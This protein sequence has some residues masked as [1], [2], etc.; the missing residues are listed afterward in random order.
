MEL[1]VLPVLR[2]KLFLMS[3]FAGR[4]S[5][6][7]TGAGA[8]AVKNMGMHKK[9]TNLVNYREMLKAERKEM[10]NISF[11]QVCSSHK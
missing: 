11:K 7:G 3:R 1:Q 5:S 6:H 4:W 9:E 8:A 2:F 10:Y